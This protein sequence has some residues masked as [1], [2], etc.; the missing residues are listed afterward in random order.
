MW[1]TVRIPEYLSQKCKTTEINDFRGKLRSNKCALRCDFQM[2]SRTG[3]EI[4]AKLVRHHYLCYETVQTFKLYRNR[5]NQGAHTIY[6]S[7]LNSEF[8][9]IRSSPR[10][11]G[12]L[13]RE[14]LRTK[15]K[16]R[17][18]KPVPRRLA[19]GPSSCE[20][21]IVSIRIMIHVP[22]AVVEKKK[23]RQTNP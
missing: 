11:Q 19:A 17:C 1:P 3:R 20:H 14:L 13:L 18:I 16:L 4:G 15:I 9:D 10:S 8:C 7:R 5:K 2:P 22:N 23:L 21:R 12:K 6:S